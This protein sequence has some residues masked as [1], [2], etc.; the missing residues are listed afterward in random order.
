M[1][2]TD[3]R[4]MVIENQPLEVEGRVRYWGGRY[5]LF[6]EV[7]TDEGITGLGERITGNTYS[8]RLGDL[9]SQIALIDEMARMHVIG[10]NPF[11]IERIWDSMYASRHDFRHPSLQ[12][13]P[14]LSAIEIALWDIVGKAGEPA[15]LQPAGRQYHEKLRAYA[16]MPEGGFRENPEKAGEIAQQL[17]DE[18]NTACKLDPF[19]PLYPIPRDIPLWEIEYAG[20][21]FESI[22][23]AVGN[24]L[25][26][27]IGT[28][29]QL[30]TYSAIRVADYLEPYHPF[31]FEEPVPLENVEEMARVAAHT[32]I[33]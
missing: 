14:V 10:Q 3:V 15:Y 1:K 11:N 24:K 7:E 25:E 29:G 6:V 18:G 31:W 26:V 12:L 8:D 30:T 19:Q 4:T 5:L 33:P 16:Y 20:K 17:L 23:N 13:T 21:I 28:H 32:S 22:R 2:V 9:K 27:G